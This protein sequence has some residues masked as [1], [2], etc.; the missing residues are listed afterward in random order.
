MNKLSEIR[1]ISNVDTKD[2]ALK[3]SN[4]SSDLKDE[5][6]IANHFNNLLKNCVVEVKFARNY[7]GTLFNHKRLADYE[8]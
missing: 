2:F 3:I 5:V 4:F 8:V 7:Y 6:I 1:E